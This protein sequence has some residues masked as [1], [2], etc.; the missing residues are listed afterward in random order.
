MPEFI[1]IQSTFGTVYVN[2]ENIL[3]IRF[4]ENPRNENP[5]V[6]IEFSNEHI[7]SEF[8][9]QTLLA[10]GVTGEQTIIDRVGKES[11]FYIKKPDETIRLGWGENEGNNEN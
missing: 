8:I 7:R 2:P 6:V 3:Y 4:S 11:T 1:R 9:E 5:S 10:L